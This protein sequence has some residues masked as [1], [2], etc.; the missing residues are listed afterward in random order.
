MD[1]IIRNSPRHLAAEFDVGHLLGKFWSLRCSAQKNVYLREYC[2][3][4]FAACLA[5]LVIVDLRLTHLNRVV[6]HIFGLSLKAAGSSDE[7][8]FVAWS[9]MRCNLE[10][11]HYGNV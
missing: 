10:E 6:Q 4:R 1:S 8:S 2:S 9:K 11:Q 7:S 3:V 5:A